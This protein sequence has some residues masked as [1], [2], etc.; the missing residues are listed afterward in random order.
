MAKSYFS[1]GPLN[2]IRARAAQLTEEISSSC[3]LDGWSICPVDP[4]RLLD[5]FSE[6]RIQ[7]GYK[8]VAYQYYSEGN[9][10][11][12][13][14]V[15]PVG[16]EL[17]EPSFA[18]GDLIEPHNAVPDL[19][20]Y[21]L[22]SGSARSYL[23]AS[24]F[25]RELAEFGA[26]W[27]G[28]DWSTHTILSGLPKEIP[29]PSQGPDWEWHEAIPE[30]WRPCVEESGVGTVVSMYTQTGLGRESILRL[31][32]RFTDAGAEFESEELAIAI[33]PGGYVF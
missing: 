17:Q 2:R 28:C 25:V 33:G 27:H 19:V 23:Q 15:V 3:L 18:R 8:L 21:I 14:F 9:G 24:L 6:L 10:G 11:T 5:L 20:R 22:P 16:K 4:M 26:M 7:D 32:D 31:T 29:G 1:V 30:Q 12:Q 13:T